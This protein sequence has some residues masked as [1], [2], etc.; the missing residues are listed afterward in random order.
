MTNDLRTKV[1][2]SIFA[3]LAWGLAVAST[4]AGTITL[5]FPG[6]GSLAGC[7]TS[8]DNWRNSSTATV[9]GYT[10][11]AGGSVVGNLLT[12]PSSGAGVMGTNATGKSS[13]KWIVEITATSGVSTFG[14]PY[15][16]ICQGGSSTNVYPGFASTCW[17]IKLSNGNRINN[18]SQT[19]CPSA[20]CGTPGNG[21]KI[22]IAYNA[23]IGAMWAGMNG[24]WWNN[25]TG[26]EIAAG[27]TTHAI[28]TSLSGTMYWVFGN[29]N[30]ATSW[31][32]NPGMVGASMAIPTGFCAW[33]T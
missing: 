22:A 19:S 10:T 8:Y 30:T 17:G 13:G 20:A 14:N 12:M 27:T 15:M 4:L 29:D 26:A 16:A 25:A 33:S 7:S 28:W 31:T 5:P 18:N 9:P 6:P 24:S 23:D 11:V 1:L 3:G 32:S 2:A 21:D